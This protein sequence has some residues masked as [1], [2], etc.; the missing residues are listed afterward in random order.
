MLYTQRLRGL[1]YELTGAR[2]SA[3][4]AEVALNVD[5]RRQSV[6][7][8]RAPAKLADLGPSTKAIAKLRGTLVGSEDCS[9]EWHAA[10]FCDTVYRSSPCAYPEYAP[11]PCEDWCRLGF[12]APGAP[13]AAP[14]AACEVTSELTA[15]VI[16]YG[17]GL[18][19]GPVS[20]ISNFVTHTR[21]TDV[22]L[23]LPDPPPEEDGWCITEIKIYQ[24]ASTW[25]GA[26]MFP[27]VDE[28]RGIDPGSM[29]SG[30]MGVSDSEY[31]L[32]DV[33]P[34]GTRSYTVVSSEDECTDLCEPITHWQ[35]CPPR[36]GMVI[37][38][39]TDNGS[40]VG[41]CGTEVW[42][43]DRDHHHAWPATGCY[44]VRECVTAVHVHNTTV[45]VFTRSKPFIIND[46][47]ELTELQCRPVMPVDRSLPVTSC[48]AVTGNDGT[49]VVCSRTGLA[50]LSPTGEVSFFGAGWARQDGCGTTIALHNGSVFYGG[51]HGHH[52]LQGLLTPRHDHS[53]AASLTD[54]SVCPDC[55]L[56]DDC[57]DL[58][59]LDG[60]RVYLWEGSDQLMPYTYQ[61]NSVHTDK[62]VRFVRVDFDRPTGKVPAQPT[63]VQVLCDGLLLPPYVVRDDEAF[64]VRARRPSRVGLRV[65]GTD[66]IVGLYAGN[67]RG[68]PN[69]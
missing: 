50:A 13:I 24:L 68:L 57:G 1:S 23:T 65:R 66:E 31:F 5:L 55:W 17:D 35:D 9:M 27:L 48:K 47:E 10:R 44:N 54:L 8:F 61:T 69:V 2:L 63:T 7:A 39:E 41:F 32:V 36:E 12:P 21:G 62:A 56:V 29:T 28:R 16:A 51:E 45:F 11:G 33:V 37:C 42:F 52:L 18:N 40:L 46:P 49:A 4:F 6:K 14:D 53:E 22:E 38:G 34:L 60:G 67:K 19:A 30:L 43:S 58:L 15:F 25:D 26:D 59:F 20:P 64:S 3:E